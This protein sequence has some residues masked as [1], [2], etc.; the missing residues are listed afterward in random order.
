[1]VQR[2][3][4][5]GEA[6][7]TFPAVVP[8]RLSGPVPS[9]PPSREQLRHVQ[10]NFCNLT[11][12][13]GRPMFTPFIMSLPDNE[14]HDWYARL[15]EAGSTHITLAVTYFY[16]SAEAIYPIPGRDWRDDLPGWVALVWEAIGAGLIPEIALTQGDGSY[17][18]PASD[19]RWFVDHGVQLMA[20]IRAAG[21]DLTD[22][23]VWRYGWEPDPPGVYDCVRTLRAAVGPEAVI[24][25]HLQADY[26]DPSGDGNAFWTNPNII[27]AK[28]EVFLYQCWPCL[29]GELD[30]YGQPLWENSA[31]QSADRLLPT[32]AA[33]PGAEG[34]RYYDDRSQTVLQHGGHALGP[35][36]LA[37]NDVTVVFFECAAY[38]YIREK[39][40]P[41]Y[42]QQVAHRARTF[43]FSWFGNG[44]PR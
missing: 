19:S 14:R 21:P 37:G 34:H 16:H 3:I 18:D 39:F 42:V 10:G 33:M 7:V 28:I 32:G 17:Q 38:H 1:M 44:V 6:A 23:C 11:D 13:L 22:W 27:A 25:L 12:A 31:I 15:L 5:A 43:G 40:G 41:E 36:Y 4:D 9:T 24:S 8:L 20:D 29:P 35:F 2:G 30:P 26:L